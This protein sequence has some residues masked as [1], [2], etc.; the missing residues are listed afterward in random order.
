MGVASPDDFFVSDLQPNQFKIPFLFLLEGDTDRALGG[1]VAGVRVVLTRV[2]GRDVLVLVVGRG[3]FVVLLGR[4]VV[5]ERVG[6]PGL[7]GVRAF[8]VCPCVFFYF[9]HN[10]P[11][12][13][14]NYQIGGGLTC[15][16]IEVP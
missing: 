14:P 10:K 11:V 4:V 9:Y 3:E 12:Y 7:V 6:L 2:V 13:R 5:F 16:V 15:D 8:W 1:W